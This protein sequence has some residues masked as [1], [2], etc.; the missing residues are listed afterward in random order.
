MKQYLVTGGAGFIGSNVVKALNDRGIENIVIV[1]N[2][3]SSE[4]WQNL[5]NLKYENYMNKADF[6]KIFMAGKVTPNDIEAIIH[7]G[8]CSST[9]EKDADYLFENNF[10]NT[11]TL[12]RWATDNN[13]RFIYASS[14]ATYGDGSKGF[15]DI[16][17]D[18]LRPLNM[19]GYSK[20]LFDLEAKKSGMISKIAGLKFFNVYGPNEYHKE[21]MMS[22]VNKSY[23]QVKETGEI[24]LFKSYKDGYG[25]G[26]QKRDF[27]YIKDVVSVIMWLLE[28]PTVNGIFNVGTGQA[29]SWVDLAKA[30]FKAMGVKENI[31]FIDMPKVLQGKYQYFTEAKME[32]L[33]GFGYTQEF[34]SLEDG[35]DDY[36]NNYLVKDDIY[37]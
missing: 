5:V 17:I 26:E 23:Y 6:I 8:A 11:N 33:R 22:V 36:I 35:V 30:V 16:S 29:R 20:Q 32:K 2:L 24:S 3:A 14:A 21:S 27:I 15:N 12:A 19:Y 25:D 10:R 18:G 13:I 1:D 28:N 34:T 31:K 4:K 7:L 37:L 9:T